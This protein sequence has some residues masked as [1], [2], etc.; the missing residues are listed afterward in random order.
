MIGSETRWP[1]GIRMRSYDVL[2]L[3]SR[4][5]GIRVDIGRAT[6]SVSSTSS[7]AIRSSRFSTIHVQTGI[8]EVQKIIPPSRG[9]L[10]FNAVERDSLYQTR[11]WLTDQNC[12]P[13]RRSSR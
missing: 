4:R 7:E 12:S 11:S 5:Y 1:Y 2:E 9:A 6:A 3:I 10:V 13:T 8:E